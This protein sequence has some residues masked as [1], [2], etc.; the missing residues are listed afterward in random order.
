[1]KNDDIRKGSSW[2]AIA[3]AI[4][5]LQGELARAGSE[6]DVVLLT[7]P[8]G[9]IV[10]TPGALDALGNAKQSLGEFLARHCAADWGDLDPDNR[11]INNDAL[12]TGGR[13]LSAYR[14]ANGQC[15]WIITE[16]DRSATTVLLPSEY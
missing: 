5:A 15:L 1:M 3:N 8:I 14:L 10:A 6:I 12:R 13:L 11:K 7:F 4:A 9:Q 16:S 2:D